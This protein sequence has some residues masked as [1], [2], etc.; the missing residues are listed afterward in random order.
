[1]QIYMQ[2]ACKLVVHYFSA[3]R[4]L[5]NIHL[6]RGNFF[7]LQHDLLCNTMHTV[8]S[9]LHFFFSNRTNKSM[10]KIVSCT[11]FQKMPI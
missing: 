1:M 4:T 3:E 8:K 7:T 10:I 2:V 9:I 6:L 5:K 11:L